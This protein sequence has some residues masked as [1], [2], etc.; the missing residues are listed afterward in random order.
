MSQ[1][2]RRIAYVFLCASPFLILVIAAAR[3]LRVSGVYQP[4]GLAIFAAVAISVWIVGRDVMR[5][6]ESGPRQ[7]A[8]AGFLLILPWA[9]ISLLWVGIG[10]PFQATLPENYMRFGVLLWDSILV[11][12][13]F[14]VLTGALHQVG[15]RIYSTVA[16][17]AA[18]P[19]GVAYLGCLSFSLAQ[20]DT[21]MRG[22]RTPLPMFLGNFYSALEFVACVMTY[23]ATLFFAVALWRTKLLRRGAACVYMVVS[24]LMMLLIIMRGIDFPEISSHT[25]PWYTRP[26]VIA[27]IPAIPWFMPGLLGVVLL[28]RAGDM[29]R[30]VTSESS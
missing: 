1:N 10:P 29:Q 27:G 9:I 8:L 28:R 26:G 7:I 23:V 15:E 18:V 20:V 14:V 24:A 16:F 19:A 30:S 11:S 12:I 4:L 22:D 13:A 3:P 5:L 6:K 17:G 2:A 21:L 25:A